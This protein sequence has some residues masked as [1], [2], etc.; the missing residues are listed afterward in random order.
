MLLLAVLALLLIV[1]HAYVRIFATVAYTYFY[2]GVL[3]K[4]INWIDASRE[5]RARQVRMTSAARSSASHLHCSIHVLIVYFS[6]SCLLLV[7]DSVG[8]YFSCSPIHQ[9]I[10]PFAH[11]PPS[12][13][14]IER[15][16][17]G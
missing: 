5:K 9:S 16:Y 4:H 17:V 11:T 3:P 14:P 15:A 1:F 6:W 7:V 13:P 2:W 10:Q 8:R 12:I